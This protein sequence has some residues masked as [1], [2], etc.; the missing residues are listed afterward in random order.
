MSW[1]EPPH[2]YSKHTLLCSSWQ[3]R[4]TS[5]E[6]FQSGA[7]SLYLVVVLQHIKPAPASA[8]AGFP[9]RPEVNDSGT[10][11]HYAG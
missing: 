8:I 11:F 4:A 2:H 5:Q 6:E 10:Y 9:T 7:R 3:G 1:L